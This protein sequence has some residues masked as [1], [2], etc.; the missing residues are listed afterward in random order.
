MASAEI[1]RVGF[2]IYDRST[3]LDFAGAT[4][5]FS[6]APGFEPIWLAPT[7]DSIETME[8]VRV[9]PG[10]TFDA[11]GQIDVL[12]VPAAATRWQP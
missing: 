8:K 7:L 1:L 5:V 10:A 3:L 6:F 4:Q 2:P 11:A 9:L 12:F